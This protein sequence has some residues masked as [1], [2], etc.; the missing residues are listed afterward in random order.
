MADDEKKND[1]NRRDF[2]KKGLKMAGALSITGLSA[3]LSGCYEFEDPIGGS[4]VWTG[5]GST[6]ATKGFVAGGFSY[7]TRVE[8]YSDS[9][10]SW[11]AVTGLNSGR[12]MLTSFS[13]GSDLGFTAGGYYGNVFEKYSDSV[14]TWST[15]TGSAARRAPGGFGLDIDSSIVG[16]GMFTGALN[17]SEKYVDSTSTWSAT[18]N[19]PL[20][21]SYMASM[22]IGTGVGIF[23]GGN[24]APSATFRYS[25]STGSWSYRAAA[26]ATARSSSPLG[27]SLGTDLG[28]VAGGYNTGAPLNTAEKYSDSA[29]SWTAIAGG[30]SYSRGWTSGFSLGSDYGFAVGGY[31]SLSSNTTEKYNNVTNSWTVSGTLTTG[32]KDHTCFSM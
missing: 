25:D 8:K 30:M 32:S 20:A 6:G 17:T 21:N 15:L 31:P 29:D 22:P 26:L 27:F 10:G 13:L 4:S 7:L 14:G 1:I 19:L 11:S 5:G 24:Y 18:G 12:H 28:F 2:I 23:A 9:T 3:G 16:G